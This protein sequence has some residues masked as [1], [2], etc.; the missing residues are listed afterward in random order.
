MAGE[1]ERP[2]VHGT[3]VWKPGAICP[4]T[5]IYCIAELFIDETR[6]IK[7]GTRFPP[8]PKPGQLWARKGHN[9]DDRPLR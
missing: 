3:H 8:T 4:V 1:N 7:K 6:T 9:S 2:I 5:G